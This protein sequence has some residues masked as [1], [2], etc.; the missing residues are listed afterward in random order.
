MANRRSAMTSSQ[1]EG[2]DRAPW[3]LFARD[4]ST[5]LIIG[6]FVIASLIATFVIYPHR[7]YSVSIDGALYLLAVTTPALAMIA[8]ARRSPDVRRPWLFM[9]GGVVANSLAD[10]V[11][12]VHDQRLHPIPNPG[13][14][15]VFYLVSYASFIIGVL[16]FTR[17]RGVR[18]RASLR[19]DGFI[20]AAAL[21]SLVSFIWFNPLAAR[22]AGTLRIVVDLA[23]PLLDLVMLMLLATA[24]A[25]RRYR[26]TWTMGLLLGGVVWLLLGDVMHVTQIATNSVHAVSFTDFTFI[27]GVWLMGL[28]ASVHDR[29]VASRHPRRTEASLSVAAIPVLS[30][31]IAISVIAACWAWNRPP[32]VGAIALL[33]LVMVRMW[34]ALREERRLVLS[35]SHDARTDSLT[36]LANRRQLFERIEELL[37]GAEALGVGIIL[38]DLDGFKEVND[39]IGHAAG[40]ELLRII[41]QR[42]TCRLANRGH[43]ARLGGDEFAVVHVASETD[44]VALA[45]ELLET[46]AEEFSLP[47]HRVRLG[48][49]MGVSVFTAEAD[50]TSRRDARLHVPVTSIT[51][52]GVSN[53]ET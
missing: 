38:I 18:P 32:E 2:R 22:G 44:L 15:D 41:S 11:Y 42:F 50:I 7:R 17:A 14:S 3:S 28:S 53:L 4:A 33:A 46:T 12:A 36:G 27:V 37:E 52:E 35:S 13:P 24:L 31:I 21:A 20:A 6:A 25:P 29:R 19:L 39:D 1:L 16:L 8:T 43:L 10:V 34:L 48:A 51:V 30:G 47:G 49:S 23:Y 9:T 40:D 5:Q 45:R 26:P